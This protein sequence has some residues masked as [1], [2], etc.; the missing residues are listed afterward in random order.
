MW[1]LQRVGVRSCGMVMIWEGRR[2]WRERSEAGWR[3]LSGGKVGWKGL[4]EE[5]EVVGLGVEGLEGFLGAIL[6]GEMRLY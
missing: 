5:V 6:G 1:V 2:V 4:D 3:G